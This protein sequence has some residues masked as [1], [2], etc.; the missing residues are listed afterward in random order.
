M[1]ST[2]TKI[3]LITLLCTLSFPGFSQKK[4]KFGKVSMEELEMSAYD[5]DTSASAVILY[6]F[7][8]FEANSLTFS[9]FMRIK[10]LKKS[11]LD[12][13]NRIFSTPSKGDF[14]VSVFNLEDGKIVEHKVKNKDIYEEDVYNDFKVYKVFAPNVKVGS[15]IDISYSHLFLPS[16]WHFQERIPVVYSHLKLE[17][18]EY[19]HYN[20]FSFGFEK[21][22]LVG[23]NEWVAR[24]VPAFKT[25]PFLSDASNYLS[26][27]EIQL[28]T[29]TVPGKFYKEYSTRWTQVSKILNESE[30]FGSI[31]KGSRYLN[32]FAKE[33]KQENISDEEKIQ[34]AFDYIQENLK[35]DGSKSVFAS[36]TT[37]SSNLKNQ[38]GNSADINLALIALLNKSGIKTHPL[39]LSTK[40]NGYVLSFFPSI[41]K[42]NY[43]VAYV[44]HTSGDKEIKMLLDATGK[45]LIPGILPTYC[46]NGQGLI[47][48]ENFERWVNLNMK[49]KEYKKQLVSVKIEPDLTSTA[50]CT[51]QF[52]DYA[53]V[54]WA[55]ERENKNNDN[56]AY[57]HGLKSK[58]KDIAILTYKVDKEEKLSLRSTEIFEA[59]LSDQMI[60]VGNDILFNPNVLFEFS[61]NPF[62]SET[63]KFPVDLTYPRKIHSIVQVHLPEKIGVKNIPASVSIANG[64]KSATFTYIAQQVNNVIQFNIT[65]DI[66]KNVFTES[67]YIDLRLFFS[68]MIMKINQPVELVKNI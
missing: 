29:I 8:H 20:K 38:S 33:L 23:H 31:L 39:V 28:Q 64:D 59:D 45:N 25:E 15:V 26:K 17:D 6:N 67:E 55:E 56:E 62:K 32:T 51:Q 18:S 11:G 49:H 9:R 40:E 5:R 4:I 46:L 27:I 57:E 43:V 34:K 41:D 36:T 58:Y 42:L 35:W 52:N 24:N 16:S 50:V 21:I 48:D 47:V 3:L 12:W 66:T 22:D 63:R 68:E 13:G 7:G 65:L 54:K 14:K 2:I 53:Y 30:K 44:E 1:R 10:I 19:L 61:E 60:I 37:P